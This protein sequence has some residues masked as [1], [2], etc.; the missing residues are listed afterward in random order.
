MHSTGAAAARQVE[1]HGGLAKVE[2]TGGQ[3]S[4]EIYLNGG[5]V[6]SWIPA[7]GGDVLFV[8]EQAR[9]QPGRAIRGGIPICFPWFG[10]KSDDAQAPAHGF[11]RLREWRL[12]TIDTRDGD[13]TVVVRTASDSASRLLWPGEFDLSLAVTFGASL[14]LALTVINTGDRP[15]RCENALHTY[16]AIGDAHRLRVRGFD[17]VRYLDKAPGGSDATQRGDITFSAETD[18]IYLEPPAQASLLDPAMAR[19]IT[20][21]NA[22]ARNAIVWNPWI[23]KARALTDLGDDEWTRMVCVESGNV[24]SAAIALEPGQ[25][26]ETR[27]TIGCTPLEPQSVDPQEAA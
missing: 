17:G 2:V 26:H 23:A 22:G 8:S 3:S 21:S 4:G 16:F 15:V 24:G 7:D 6:T 13:V 11:V 10:A 18:R 14:H 9:W 19:R 20:I 12:D 1:G 27:V 25:Q 5:Q